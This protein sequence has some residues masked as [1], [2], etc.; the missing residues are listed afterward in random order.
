MGITRINSKPVN[1]PDL[2]NR[3]AFSQAGRFSPRSEQSTGNEILFTP[4]LEE[5]M[6]Q[7]Q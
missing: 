2:G 3:C 5:T 6:T 4:R 1:E 7:L